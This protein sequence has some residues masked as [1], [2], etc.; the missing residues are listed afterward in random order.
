MLLGLGA[1]PAKRADLP[2]AG[3]RLGTLIQTTRYPGRYRTVADLAAWE[4]ANNPIDDPDSNPVGLLAENGRYLVAD[5]GGNTVLRVGDRGRIR[6]VAAFADTMVDAPPF[7]GLPPGTQIPMQAVPTSVA[8]KGWDGAY[9]V[10]QLTGFPFPK[11]AASIWRID[12]R[13]GAKTVYASGLTNVTDLAFRGSTL[14]AVQLADE[15]LLSG[16]TGSLVKVERGGATPEDL[17]VVAG[18]LFAPYGLALSGRTAYV[19]TGSV[20]PGAGQVIKVRL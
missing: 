13:T 18:N 20:A 17:T 10:S 15:G 8:T 2:R 19:T 9:Y 11:G 7:L 12:P 5:A 3:Q 6:Q 14:Y 16:P 4:G 1:D